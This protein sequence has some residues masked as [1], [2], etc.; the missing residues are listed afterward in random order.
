MRVSEGTCTTNTR[1]MQKQRRA[2]MSWK[3]MLCSRR[4]RAKGAQRTTLMAVPA[5]RTGPGVASNT[6]C[7]PLPRTTPDEKET[8]QEWPN[9]RTRRTSLICEDRSW[10]GV[11]S[12]GRGSWGG[13]HL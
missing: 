8:P 13:E 3:R 9:K 6:T 7:M 10:R 1:A 2:D 12:D 11:S 4:T 5:E